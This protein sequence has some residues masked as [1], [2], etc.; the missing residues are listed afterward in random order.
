M[1]IIFKGHAALV[2]RS[3]R[4]LEIGCRALKPSILNYALK[5]LVFKFKLYVWICVP[6][7]MC[8]RR[9]AKVSI[10][11]ELELQGVVSFPASPLVPQL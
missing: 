11:L 4:A 1:R 6:E 5:S 8:R 7:C 10:P 9:L 2:L 3:T